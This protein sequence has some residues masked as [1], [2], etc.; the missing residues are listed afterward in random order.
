MG[1]YYLLY[2]GVKSIKSGV[3]TLNSKEIIQKNEKNTEGKVKFYQ[4]YGWF[5]DTNT[6]S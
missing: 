1:G 3:N 4:L 6:Q 2:M 5:Y